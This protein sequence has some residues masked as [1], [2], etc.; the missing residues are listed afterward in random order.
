M[1]RMWGYQQC[2][3][4]HPMIRSS[5]FLWSNGQMA[6]LGVNLSV[7]DKDDTA[8]YQFLGLLLAWKYA[9]YF[10]LSPVLLTYHPYI[11][12]ISKGL[13][14]ICRW[15]TG[16]GGPPKPG[17]SAEASV[18]KHLEQQT[19]RHGGTTWENMWKHGK[20]LLIHIFW[21]LFMIITA[22]DVWWLFKA[23]R[24]RLKT[25]IKMINI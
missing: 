25:G 12:L 8:K 11:S 16:G 1:F 17:K 2:T 18:S 21:R 5:F 10:L 23:Q 13:S 4:W 3:W 22:D 20:M 14:P 6:W 24:S 15:L 19:G 7:L 9:C